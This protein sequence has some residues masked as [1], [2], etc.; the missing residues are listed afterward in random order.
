MST[1]LPILP[2]SDLRDNEDKL[3]LAAQQAEE[4]KNRMR[5]YFEKPEAQLNSIAQHEPVCL[6]LETTNRCNLLCTT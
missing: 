4:E 2:S 3:S 6:Y 5:R 1:L